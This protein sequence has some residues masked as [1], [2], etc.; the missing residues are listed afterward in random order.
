MNV[1]NMNSHQWVNAE[2]PN[3]LEVRQVY[4]FIFNF[5]GRILLLED[6]GEYNLPGG[7]SERGESLAETLI[8]EV[9][10]EVQITITSSIYLGYQ[11][12]STEEEFAQVR[13]VAWI[14]KILQATPDPSTGRQ[15]KRLLVPPIQVSELLK[16]GESGDQQIASAIATA[17]KFGVNW[18]GTP[19]TIIEIN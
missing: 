11:F 18:D 4:G 14:D 12:I 7:K 15:Y 6:Q 17:S 10:E 19:L 16:W 1:F 2:V 9:L 8:R 3:G 5:D 13:L